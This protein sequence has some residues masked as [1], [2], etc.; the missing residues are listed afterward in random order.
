MTRFWHWFAGLFIAL[1]LVACG[2]DDGGG[3]SPPPPSAKSTML[4]YL[5]ASDLLD[6]RGAERDLVNMLKARS[7][8]DVNVVLQIGGGETAGQ[9]PGVDMQQTRRYRLA[10][11]AQPELGWML[12]PL[13]ADQQPPQVAMN[14]PDTLRDFL[15]WGA[16]Q[17]PAQQYAL[18]L[19]DH[20]S[21]PIHG[22]GNDDALGG[23]KALSL[24][25]IQT[26]LRQAGVHFELIGFDACLMA[27]LEVA[28]ALA[29]HANYLV[30]SEEVT[31]GWDWTQV[32]NF[33]SAHPDARGDAL[34]RA[35]VDS[36]KA[37]EGTVDY[38]AYSVTDL[39]RV[40]ALV[41]ALDGVA[42]TL[43]QALHTQGLPAWW[44][45]ST[46][47]REAQDFQTNIFQT[48]MD[49]VDVM[50]WIDE[51]GKTGVLP[52]QQVA[53][54]RAAYQQAV[55]HTDGSEDDA[56]GLMM[57]F[58]RFSTL[59]PELLA[60]YAAIDFSPAFQEWVRVY[61]A[62]AA[63]GQVPHIVVGDPRAQAGAAVAD[64]AIAPQDATKAAGDA[65]DRLFDQG[66]AVL[67]KDGV[68][69]SMQ[70][71]AVQGRQLRLEQA[72]RWPMV[73][74]E[75]VSLLPVDDSDDDVVQIPVFDA[76]GDEGM[77]L[78]MRQDDGRLLI[79]WHISNKALA[80][81]SAAMAKVNPGQ[82]FRPIMLDVQSGTM[83]VPST[84]LTAPEGDW[85]VEM[86]TLRGSGYTLHMAASDLMGQL[87]ASTQGL[88]LPLAP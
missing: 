28:H 21:G 35:I 83:A 36:Y 57:Y 20:G 87:R 15:Q 65:L 60:Q 33:L 76:E 62:F 75:I 86:T 42:T 85:A 22:F 4:V 82:V 39:Q 70:A 58:P 56:T 41:T 53:E 46:A 24:A 14:Q 7:N 43:T 63:S 40:P 19:W 25:D 38:T 64:V 77:L 49:L 16:R 73:D 88:A 13:P 59:N 6:G 71:A 5:V 48:D 52:P 45:V 29:P 2:G 27:S 84:E 12:E 54:F 1:A 67:V 74:G 34:G 8:P 9:F 69:L 32:V 55:I 66:Y 68:A 51:L 18:T 37:F 44:A 17:Y 78:A 72:N 31:T 26:A 47:R 50:S 79:Q 23:G 30:G 10:P 3:D 80:G 11:Q 61:A 81:T